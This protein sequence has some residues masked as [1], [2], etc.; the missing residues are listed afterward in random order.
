MEV[1]ENYK[2]LDPDLL[3]FFRP[4]EKMLKHAL[5]TEVGI[6]LDDKTR[7]SFVSLMPKIWRQSCVKRKVN[8]C[9]CVCVCV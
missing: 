4:D 6:I 8:E 2:R 1:A 3:R 5:L 9:V 7:K